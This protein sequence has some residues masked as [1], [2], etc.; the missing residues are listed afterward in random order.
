M[1][2]PICVTSALVANAPT[3]AAAVS[4]IT[5]AKMLHKRDQIARTTVQ[6]PSKR[7]S[8]KEQAD[9]GAPKAT[10]WLEPWRSSTNGIWKEE[11]EDV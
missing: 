6:A 1:V 4:G 7:S 9:L 2:C 11:E 3:I 8:L 5:A 10:M